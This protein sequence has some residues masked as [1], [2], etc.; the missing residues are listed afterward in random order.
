MHGLSFREITEKEFTIIEKWYEM[1]G[2]FGHAT[3]FKNFSEAQHRLLNLS[4]KTAFVICYESDTVGFIF[5]EIIKSTGTPVLWIYV[6]LIEP[7]YQRK[8]FGTWAVNRLIDITKSEY[9]TFICIAPVSQ[10]NE[11]GL[12]FWES[13][14]FVRSC[15]LEKNLKPDKQ[16]AV[17]IRNISSDTESH[18]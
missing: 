18:F 9:D 13:L 12:C 4:G 17:F 10:K 1:T 7:D 16:V 8:G 11:K 6:L 2:C 14:G 5:A 3:G 15:N